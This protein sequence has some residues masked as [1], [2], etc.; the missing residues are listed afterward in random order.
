MAN[1]A[2]LGWLIDPQEQRIWIYRSGRAPETLERPERV[3]GEGC[4]AGFLLEL[5]EIWQ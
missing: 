3:A 1:G 5:E 2:E 4:I